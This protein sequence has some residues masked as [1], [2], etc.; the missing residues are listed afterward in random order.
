[1][2]VEM[3]ETRVEELNTASQTA[4]TSIAICL[5]EPPEVACLARLTRYP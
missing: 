4:W 1:M 3:L 5:T 2:D